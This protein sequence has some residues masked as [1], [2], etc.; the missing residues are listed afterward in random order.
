MVQNKMLSALCIIVFPLA[1]F[2]QSK[3][4]YVVSGTIKDK[5]TGETL[6]GATIGFLGH[7]GWGVAT[8]AYGFYSIT[9]PEGRYSMIISYSGNATDTVDLELN[10]NIVLNTSMSASNSSQLQEVV[11]K[12]SRKSNNILRTP[13]GVQ[14]LSMEDIKNVPVLLG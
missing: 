13:A 14:H 10:H 3:H 4:D 2:A 5:K 11:I 12:S 8:N 7:P 6:S 1:I 9:I